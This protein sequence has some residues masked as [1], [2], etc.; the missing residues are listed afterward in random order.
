MTK[1]FATE[2]MRV[3]D[4]RLK[5]L[6]AEPDHLAV[7]AK[8]VPAQDA[9]AFY[10]RMEQRGLMWLVKWESGLWDIIYASDKA[11]PHE[12]G[13]SSLMTG[14]LYAIAATIGMQTYALDIDSF[15]A[16]AMC[17]EPYMVMSA[18]IG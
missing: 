12:Y 9:Q 14:I 18:M 11:V 16:I 15:I 8:H 1:L 4:R 3:L 2:T 13:S 17:F 7:L 5:E 6:M 10:N